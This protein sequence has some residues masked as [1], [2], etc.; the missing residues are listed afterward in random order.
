MAQ[1][2]L[3]RVEG[4]DLPFRVAPLDLDGNEPFLDLAFEAFQPGAHEH[5]AAH[6]IA[7]EEVARKL[8]GDGARTTTLTKAA[9]RNPV[10]DVLDARN[11]DPREAQPEVLLELRVLLCDDGLT[12]RRC[13]VLVPNDHSAF[14]GKLT[15]YLPIACKQ[16]RDRARTVVVQ[17]ADFGQ[18]RPV[19]EEHTS[20]R[21]EQPSHHEHH[22]E[23]R[24][25]RYANYSARANRGGGRLLRFLHY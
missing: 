15:D 17:S 7:K 19:G 8:L 22:H 18:V 11:H 12:E 20:E 24:P 5:A 9:P 2:D 10:Q 23:D 25:S 14:G 13:D 1:I 6:V 3:V 16:A 4:E 21:S